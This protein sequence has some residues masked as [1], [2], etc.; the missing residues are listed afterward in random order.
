MTQNIDSSH[1]E[2]QLPN[3]APVGPT[4]GINCDDISSPVRRSLCRA[5]N[6]PVIGAAPFCADH[7]EVP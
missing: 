4:P 3:E 2:P 1:R 5:C 6:S 7:F